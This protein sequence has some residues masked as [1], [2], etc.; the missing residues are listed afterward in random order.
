MLGVTAPPILVK[1]RPALLT[2]AVSAWDLTGITMV[3]C[4]CR[5]DADM[6]H[7]CCCVFC[8]LLRTVVDRQF[9]TGQGPSKCCR[10]QRPAVPAAVAAVHV[11]AILPA[12]SRD[13][14]RKALDMFKHLQRCT[15]R[16]R[17]WDLHWGDDLGMRVAHTT[18]FELI[19][20]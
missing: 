16:A 17:T 19:S 2:V 9:L 11:V 8:R 20:S 14:V 1:P 12:H 7:C 6:L 18:T 10:L 15:S 13:Y 5:H 4:S 3:L